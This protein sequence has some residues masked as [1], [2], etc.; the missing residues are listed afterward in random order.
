[1]PVPKSSDFAHVGHGEQVAGV[2]QGH[3]ALLGYGLGEVEFAVDVGG[4]DW[5]GGVEP[6]DCA[7][8]LIQVERELAAPGG[9]KRSVDL[10][11]SGVRIKLSSDHEPLTF[12]H[13]YGI[14][15]ELAVAAWRPRSAWQDGSGLADRATLRTPPRR[16]RGPP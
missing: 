11:D 14:P 10:A 4:V 7:R 15:V 8:D 3:L 12:D 9:L 6:A 5:E 1:M 2:S 13:V 16:H